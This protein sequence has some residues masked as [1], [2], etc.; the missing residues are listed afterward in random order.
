MRYP[1]DYGNLHGI[2]CYMMLYDVKWL[3]ECNLLQW[4]CP[5]KPPPFPARALRAAGPPG[6]WL[7]G[8]GLDPA[9]PLAAAHCGSQHRRLHD[10]EEQHCDQLQG[11][12][13]GKTWWNDGNKNDE[14]MGKMVTMGK[15][16]M[17]LFW[18]D[19]GNMMGDDERSHYWMILE[20][21][22]LLVD[23]W[24]IDSLWC[25][26]GGDS[27][28]CFL[29]PTE[30]ALGKFSLQ[31][32][33]MPDVGGCWR[34]IFTGF[35]Q[36][37]LWLVHSQNAWL[38]VWLPFLIFPYLGNFII[39]I[40]ELIFLQRGGEKPPTR[41]AFWWFSGDDPK[42]PLWGVNIPVNI[43]DIHS[44]E[45]PVTCDARCGRQL[46]WQLPTKRSYWNRGW[47]PSGKL[48]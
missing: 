30:V 48:T 10:C 5:L 7:F 15:W 13:M 27:S 47:L 29:T 24:R 21:H 36:A 41:N 4:P 12:L 34:I 2:W 42:T 43:P 3:Y 45:S 8:G 35:Y 25:V 22:L 28:F 6:P 31:L 46:P 18:E 14:M 17:K 33:C 1:H 26:V 32:H 11:D 38:V 16:W 40:D 39:P 44:E 37:V 19:D 9:E 20:N 23:I